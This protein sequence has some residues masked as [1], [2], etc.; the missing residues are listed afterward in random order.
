MMDEKDIDLEEEIEEDGIESES[1]DDLEDEDLEY[2]EDGNVNIPDDEES[3][4]TEESEDEDTEESSDSEE[5]EAT[6][7]NETDTEKEEKESSAEAELR[8]YKRQ[9]RDTLKKYGIEDAD[10]LKGLAQI[11]ADSEGKELSEYLK[12]QDEA[13]K[14]E[15]ASIAAFEV[16]AKKDLE[17]LQAVFPETVSY[18]SVRD[19]PDE[20]LKVFAQCR[21]MGLNAVQAYAAANPRGARVNATPTKKPSSN[22]KEHLKSSVPKGAEGAPRN[23]SKETIKEWAEDLGCSMKEA[24]E[25]Y[26]NTL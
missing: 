20:M 7:E 17:E 25:I 10:D 19:M 3:D 2:D 11:A 5:P 8:E 15:A 22:G 26:I 6:E 13:R 12:E 23:I 9:V 14:A 1:T 18:K 21:D 16:I 4:D 24:R